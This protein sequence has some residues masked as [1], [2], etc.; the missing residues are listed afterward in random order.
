MTNELQSTKRKVRSVAFGG[1]F[2]SFFIVYDDGGWYFNNIP[3]KL[4]DRVATKKRRRN[5]DVICVSL[6]PNDEYF[7]KTESSGMEWIASQNTVKETKE[8]RNRL[9]FIDFGSD[10]AYLLRY[11]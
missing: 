10:D 3:W 9:T 4:Q 6:G 7:L 2:D 5:P 8:Y 1:D 11:S